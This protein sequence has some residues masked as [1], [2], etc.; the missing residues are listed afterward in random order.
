[1]R[2]GAS[3]AIG[4]DLNGVQQQVTIQISDFGRHK[5]VPV[6]FS[7]AMQFASTP[8]QQSHKVEDYIYQVVFLML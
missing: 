2:K 7:N 1:M 8:A 5:G 3:P 4:V 6:D